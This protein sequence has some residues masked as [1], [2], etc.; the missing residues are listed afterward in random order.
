MDGCRRIEIFWRQHP[1][2]I[3]HREAI[4]E[5][6]LTPGMLLYTNYSSKYS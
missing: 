6:L 3:I 2:K 4:C 1:D 5:V